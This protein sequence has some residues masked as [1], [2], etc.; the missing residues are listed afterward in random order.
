[1]RKIVLLLIFIGFLIAILL[2]YKSVKTQK[3]T[4]DNQNSEITTT[5]STQ[6]FKSQLEIAALRARSYPGSDIKI[7]QTLDA[8]SNYKRYIAS[9]VS[10][11]FKIYGLLTVP[12]SA[13][14]SSR[15]PVVIFNHGYIPPNEYQTTERYVAYQDGFAR[16]GYV[17]F[18]S[19]Y[20]G[21][22]RSEGQAEGAYFSP[23]Y[24]IDVLNALASIKKLPYVNVD[25]IG[26]WGHSMGGNITLRVLVVE[27]NSIKVA[28]IWSGVVGTY[29]DLLN[30]WHP[31]RYTPQGAANIR[32]HLTSIR[33]NLV[34]HFGTPQT[35]PSFWSSI[36]PYTYIQSVGAPVQIHQ[37]MTDE[38]VPPSF[39]EHLR[40][41]LQKNGKIIDY[42]SYQNA[43]HNLS[44]VFNIAL[45][46]S[47]AFFDKYLK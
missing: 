11:N 4:T 36:D 29:D 15:V 14:A 16:A 2:I 26:M 13:S 20:R 18:K 9:Y 6:Q 31:N 24:T 40:N 5:P 17:T 46:R 34:D 47:V 21:N 28:V 19:D 42:Y 7:E 38:D 12:D 44:Q 32:E 33:Q 8:G 23:D 35:N 30:H 3:S 45:Q 39:A 27:P 43:D 37:S 10:D 41:A 1:M 22:G 25:K